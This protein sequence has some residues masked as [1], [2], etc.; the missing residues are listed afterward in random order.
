MGW[1]CD[2][3]ASNWRMFHGLQFDAVIACGF[4]GATLY[5]G[6]TL[7]NK[8]IKG[9]DGFQVSMVEMLC[10]VAVLLPYT[11]VFTTDSWAIPDTTSVVNLVLIGVLHTGVAYGM[12][13][14]AVQKVPAQRAAIY[15]FADP[16]TALII[17]ATV[18]GESMTWVQVTGAVLILGGAM[19]AELSHKK[20][21]VS[22]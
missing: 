1:S 7:V 2:M 6:I 14:S 13:F 16:F 8:S 10:A 5:A 17:S 11:V 22:P 12:Y 18:L 4:V 20:Q 21:D 9:L 19:V 15:S 3:I